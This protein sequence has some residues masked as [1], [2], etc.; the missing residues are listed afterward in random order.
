MSPTC[1]MV[2]YATTRLASL[3]QLPIHPAINTW[4]APSTTQSPMPSQTHT[5]LASTTTPAQTNV[6][7][8][9]RAETGVGPSIASNSHE[10][11]PSKADFEQTAHKR[12][13]ATRPR[14]L[15][16]THHTRSP[17]DSRPDSPMDPHGPD[18]GQSPR[19]RS[20]QIGPLEPIQ[21]EDAHSQDEPPMAK[22]T[23]PVESKAPKPCQSWTLSP[24]HPEQD[25]QAKSA[26][27][28][29]VKVPPSY[30]STQPP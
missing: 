15:P 28:A 22:P 30:G 11:R 20:P 8:C 13:T 9:S 10:C 27:T 17:Q 29:G 16:P 26:R 7:L 4:Q 5:Y 25:D 19:T 3:N 12:P 1:T 21:A 23:K 6:A 18:P 14:P 2:D 24:P